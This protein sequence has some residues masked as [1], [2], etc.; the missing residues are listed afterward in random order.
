MSHQ[1]SVDVVP[2]ARDTG[3]WRSFTAG[4]GSNASN[5]SGR[6]ECFLIDDGANDPQIW[7]DRLYVSAAPGG[8]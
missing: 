6:F 4:L 7:L 3:V 5:R 1:S 2:F 8:F